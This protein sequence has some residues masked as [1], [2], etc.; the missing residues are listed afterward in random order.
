MPAS[1][2]Q[3]GTAQYVQ[4]ATE[5]EGI[6]ARYVTVER[7]AAE[8]ALRTVVMDTQACGVEGGQAGAVLAAAVAGSPPGR[9]KDN[10]PHGQRG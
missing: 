6:I 1:P 8:C 3:Q 5:Q 7:R 4:A 10:E 2:G 9:V